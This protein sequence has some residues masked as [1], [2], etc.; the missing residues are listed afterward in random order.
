MRFM[1]LITTFIFLSFASAALFAQDIA[2]FEKRITMKKL[3]NGLTILIMERPE[4][5]VFSFFT[6]VKAGATQDPEGQSGLA[7]MFEHMAFKG[8]DKIGTTNYAAEKLAL[9][10]VDAAYK[11][12]DKERSKQVG[13]DQKKVDEL[14][15]TFD[16]AVEKAQQY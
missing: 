13:K 16:A 9:D 4:A 14:K 5:P 7:H 3:P 2:S 6:Y 10:Q 1:R 12:W 8:T 11:A 15:K